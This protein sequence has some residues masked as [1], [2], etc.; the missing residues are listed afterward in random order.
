MQIV[1][2]LYQDYNTEDNELVY[3]GSMSKSRIPK[4]LLPAATTIYTPDWATRYMVQNS[5]GRLWCEGHPNFARPEN[6]KYYLTEA[7]QTQVTQQKLAEIRKG[8]AALQPEEIKVI[9]PCSGS[10][11]ILVHMFDTLMQIYNSVGYSDRDAVRSIIENSLYGLDVSDRAAQLSYFAVMMKARRYDKRFLTR[12]DENGKPD[13]PQAKVYAICESNELSDRQWQD[14]F[15][16]FD[17]SADRD[18]VK[19]LAEE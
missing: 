3:D 12:K 5:L 15:S 19:Y 2:W 13:V 1:G 6:W 14:V 17:N 16:E 9:D 7:P 4:E 8:Y 11:H 10:G 18:I